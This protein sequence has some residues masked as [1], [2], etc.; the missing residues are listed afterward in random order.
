M[1]LL[2]VVNAGCC[3][4]LLSLVVTI[5][6][7]V[8]NKSDLPEGVGIE[9]MKISMVEGSVGADHGVLIGPF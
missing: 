5:M 9:V 2:L 8:T 3:H 4:W 1:L 7:T 6:V